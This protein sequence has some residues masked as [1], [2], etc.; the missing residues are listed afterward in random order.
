ML[1]DKDIQVIDGLVSALAGYCCAG[2]QK[3][4][5]LLAEYLFT[6][7]E[8]KQLKEKGNA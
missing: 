5:D 1:T 6:Y 7:D 8:Y 4:Y 3:I 2:K